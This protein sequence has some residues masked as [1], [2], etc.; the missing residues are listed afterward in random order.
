MDTLTFLGQGFAVALT[1]MNLLWSLVG[2]TMGTL[3]GILPGIGPALTIALLLP[4]TYR[5]DPIAAFVM[6]G[7]IYYGAMY[8]SSTTAILIKTPGETGSLITTI[9]GY[10]M[11]LKG[12]APAALATAAIGS[13]IAGLIGT[14]LM[15]LLAPEVV[16]LALWF[17]P[18]DYFALMCVAFVSVSALLGSSIVRGLVSL[19][20]GLAV[21]LIG[22][23]QQTGAAR[24]TF[25][26]LELLDG[27]SI[28]VVVVGLFAVGEAL[29]LASQP[30]GRQSVV[31][32]AGPARMSQE[33]WRRSWMPWLR[34]SLIGFPL[35]ALPAGGTEL[36]TFISYQVEKRLSNSP[37][38]FGAGAIEGV[39]GPE[40][41]NNS[42]VAGVLVPLLT[43]GL[44][45]SSTAAILLAAFQQYGIQPGPLLF[46]SSPNLVWGLIASLFIGN[47]MLLVLNLPLAGL[48]ARLLY[49][50][51]HWLYG[52]ILVFAVLGVY[53]VNRSLF[54]I[55]VLGLF[56]LLG[57][58]MR[59]LDFPVAPVIVGM[60]LG[61]MAEVQFR[62]AIQITQGDLSIF[63]T[64]PISLI[65]LVIAASVLLTPL[66]KLALRGGR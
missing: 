60:I 4:V 52:G 2:V 40:A 56:G 64:R 62:R 35:G 10:Q 6:F 23:D 32:L 47:F 34:G 19:F 28:V 59:R 42:A 22:I 39:A 54:E 37:Q 29:F 50:P 8:G 5:L 25:D 57:Y 17:G 44:P 55:A 21:A 16:K 27:I 9:D 49:I 58:A 3:I 26:T 31:P 65:L 46:S 63:V 11:A 1:P 15:A 51:R 13:F 12:K 41:A 14:V 18:A 30:E 53:G 45:T 66:I 61:P 24:F 20:I 33:D 43:L 7:G 36:P 48:W 38:E